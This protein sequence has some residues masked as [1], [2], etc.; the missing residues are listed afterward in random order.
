MLYPEVG[1]KD[2]GARFGVPGLNHFVG[3]ELPIPAQEYC[4]HPSTRVNLH[5]HGLGPIL[6]R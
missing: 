6:G 4:V 5:D 1:S 3:E 2:K